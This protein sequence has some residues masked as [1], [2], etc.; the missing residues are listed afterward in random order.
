[1]VLVN[2]SNENNLGKDYLSDEHVTSNDLILT[3]SITS[4]QNLESTDAI[5]Y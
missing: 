2:F 3:G 1:M 4:T 5:D